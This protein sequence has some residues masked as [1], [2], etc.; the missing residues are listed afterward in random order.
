MEGLQ[1][2]ISRRFCLHRRPLE[3]SLYIE[4]QQKIVS[5][6]TTIRK[7][8]LYRSPLRGCISIGDLWEIISIQKVSRRSFLYRSHQ[9]ILLHIEGLWVVFPFKNGSINNISRRPVGAFSSLSSSSIRKPLLI[10]GRLLLKKRP[11][12]SLSKVFCIQRDYA[13]SSLFIKKAIQESLRLEIPSE[14]LCVEGLSNG[15]SQVVHFNYQN[16]KSN[17]CIQKKK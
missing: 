14:I 1:N 6:Q 4:S 16:E 3:G 10:D 7:S 9:G 15:A 12:G 2:V 13:K 11:L 5:V 8:S 17:Y